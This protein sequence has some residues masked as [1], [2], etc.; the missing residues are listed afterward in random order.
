MR[1]AGQRPTPCLTIKG[2]LILLMTC[3]DR[4]GLNIRSKAA[5]I[6]MGWCAGDA[7][8]IEEAKQHA[9]DPNMQWMRE[10]VE[11]E[12]RNMVATTVTEDS[13]MEVCHDEEE[14][15]LARSLRI[16]NLKAEIATKQAEALQGMLQ[17]NK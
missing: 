4:L 2:T 15:Q 12:R 11:V 8:W 10:E 14:T 13:R 3:E 9:S 17:K 16:A 7:A 5:D 1:C 6:L